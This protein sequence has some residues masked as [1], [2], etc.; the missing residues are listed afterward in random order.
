MSLPVIICYSLAMSRIGRKRGGMEEH[1]SLAEA[2]ERMGISERTARRWIKSGKLR[3]YKPGR[4]YWIPERALTE[5]VEESKVS[6]KEPASPSPQQPNFN[7]L[8]EEE[9]RGMELE[10]IR[11]SYRATREG[12]GRY[13]DVWERRIAAD[14]LDRESVWGFLEVA[15]ALL[16]AATDS[17]VSELIGIS[18]VVDHFEG[19]SVSEE[20]LAEASVKPVVDRYHAIGRRLQ[21]VWREKFAT[22]TGAPDTGKLIEVDFRALRAEDEVRKRRT[23]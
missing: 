1:L 23:G 14:D 17:A 18:S 20:A 11:E 7:G 9:R 5:L 22:D 6:P 19:D 8:L 2:A 12:L 3:A 16:P 13:C 15:D 21:E 10:E 4:D